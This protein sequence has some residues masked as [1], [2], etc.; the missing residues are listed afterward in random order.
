VVTGGVYFLPNLVVLKSWGIDV[1]LGMDWL[2]SC[3]GVIQCRKRSVLLTSPQG[4]RIEY[5]STPSS[6]SGVVNSVEGKVLTVYFGAPSMFI[7]LWFGFDYGTNPP[8][9]TLII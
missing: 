5:V 1:I 3:D 9:G 4:E 2:R 6:R 7:T 8:L